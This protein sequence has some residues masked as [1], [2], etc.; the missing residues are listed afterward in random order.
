MKWRYPR[1]NNLIIF[2]TI[3]LHCSLTPWDKNLLE[4]LSVTHMVKKYFAFLW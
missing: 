4:K 2:W 3:P 1:I